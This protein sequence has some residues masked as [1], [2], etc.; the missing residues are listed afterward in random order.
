MGAKIS[1]GAILIVAWAAVV[2]TV[3]TQHKRNS[4]DLACAN[5]RKFST[6]DGS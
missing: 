3:G 5:A 1:L 6:D 2:L 4:K